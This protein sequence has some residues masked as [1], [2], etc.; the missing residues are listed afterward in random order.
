MWR[1][2]IGTNLRVASAQRSIITDLQKDEAYLRSVYVDYGRAVANV[3]RIQQ[4]VLIFSALLMQNCW[5]T[6]GLRVGDYA[7]V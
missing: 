2:C 1:Y 7:T 3:M 4:T 6:V 5:M